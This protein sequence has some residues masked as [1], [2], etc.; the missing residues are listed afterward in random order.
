MNEYILRTEEITKTY[1]NYAAVNK[2]NLT[3]KKGDIY[4]FIGQ[5]G[6]GKST[7]LRLVTGLGF[8]DS[9]TLEIFGENADK[10]LNAAQKRIGA[11]IENPALFLN[12]TAEQN[13]EV[14]RLQKGIPGKQCIADT[15]KLV[16]LENTG[17]KKVKNFSLGMKQ[18][19][20]LATALLG[21][22]EFLILDE[23]TNGLD[24]IGIVELRGLIQKL[25]REKGLT[26]LIS[27][28]ILSELYQLATTYG[29]IH[30][31]RLIE[32][33][34]LRELDNKCRQHLK[35]KV[36]DTEKGVTILEEQLNTTDFEVSPDGSISLYNHLN[37]VRKV[38]SA[39][40]S[41]GLIIEH[42]SQNGDSLE[43]YFSKLVGGDSHE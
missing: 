40:T 1:K 27:S 9:G 35:I 12:M 37:E 13:L 5:N 3:V 11:I 32:E 28:H 36:N 23:P 17:N 16:E 26:V 39:L 6:A 24:P 7:M 15:L 43:S 19:L 21:D 29:I 41:G 38:S 30:E 14:H 4:G 22:P 8:P 25:N 20:G 34:T 31:G 42:L 2:V 10:G 33:L 18:R